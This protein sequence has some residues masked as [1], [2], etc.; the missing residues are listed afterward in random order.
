MVLEL[1]SEASL[2]IHFPVMVFGTHLTVVPGSHLGLWVCCIV[3]CLQYRHYY[4]ATGGSS[5]GFSYKF[6]ARHDG[7]LNK[8]WQCFGNL[9]YIPSLLNSGD[10][11][12]P[13]EHFLC[14]L[15]YTF[16][17]EEEVWAISGN[18]QALF[19]A[20]L[21]SYTEIKPGSVTG[22]ASASPPILSLTGPVYF[23]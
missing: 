4:L 15:L 9:F 19:Q 14:L 21:G 22:K 11:T 3:S 18:V 2:V 17:W 1:T 7:F 8:N 6:K 10:L 20:E 13:Y 16:V 12:C 23:F 5:E